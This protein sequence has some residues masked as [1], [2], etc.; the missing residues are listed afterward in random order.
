MPQLLHYG[1]RIVKHDTFGRRRRDTAK[2]GLK[3]TGR[4]VYSEHQIRAV[5]GPR[6]VILSRK[7]RNPYE[8][9]KRQK[10]LERKKKKELK[11]EQRLHR[12]EESQEGPDEEQ[13]GEE[14]E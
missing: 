4:S 10:E 8:S 6:G 14:T 1:G 2:K 5:P 9:A 11:K 12:S 13:G 7:R 3:C